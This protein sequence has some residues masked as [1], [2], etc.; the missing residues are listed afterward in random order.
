[1]PAEKIL[2][3]IKDEPG[4]KWTK[5]LSTSSRKRDPEKYYRFH[6][7][8]GH[9]TDE[10][11]DLKEQIEELIQQGKLQKFIKR[12]Q[13]PRSRIDDKPHDDSKDDGWDHPKQVIGEIRMIIGGPVSG[14]SYKFL[15]KTYQRQ[16]NSIH[17]KHPSTKYRRSK[18]DDITFSE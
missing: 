12:D 3:Q 6:K 18:S 9:Y 11:C 16:I 7:D 17:I 14:G 13:Q 2:M 5:L 10:C 8:H 4:L 15:K 1:M